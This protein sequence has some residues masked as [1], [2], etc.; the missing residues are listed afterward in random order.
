VPEIEGEQ[1]R[2]RNT[3]Q[4]RILLALAGLVVLAGAVV[5][6]VV[7]GRTVLDEDESSEPVG[8]PP[9]PVG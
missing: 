6:G 4:R 8:S 3:R 2:R 9:L 7:L 5:G 1:S